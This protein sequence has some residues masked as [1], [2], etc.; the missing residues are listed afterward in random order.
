MS[1]RSLTARRRRLIGLA[2]LAVALAGLF[3][4]HGLSPH[5]TTH[6]GPETAAAHAGE[7]P[8][9]S[10]GMPADDGGHDTLLAM[11]LALLVAGVIGLA[12][13]GR[14]FRWV[15]RDDTRP[16]LVALP[17]TARRDRDPPDLHALSI[18]RC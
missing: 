1:P 2:V 12:T 5:G 9:P 11:C 8:A 4:M 7:H 15:I 10:G 13:R 17:W 14:S 16:G 18:Q 3:V 6:A